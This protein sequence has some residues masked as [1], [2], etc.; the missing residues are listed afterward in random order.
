MASN[1]A[2][3]TDSS[4]ATFVDDSSDGFSPLPDVTRVQHVRP[5]VGDSEAARVWAGA[6]PARARREIN[7]S[8]AGA[9]PCS[10]TAAP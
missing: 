10:V 1:G 4:A 2:G 9:R 7:H 6:S 8:Y 3:F 5:V